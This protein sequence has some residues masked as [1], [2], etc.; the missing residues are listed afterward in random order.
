MANITCTVNI[1]TEG[2]GY[3]VIHGGAVSTV[4]ATIR[5][6]TFV[7]IVNPWDPIGAMHPWNYIET[8]QPD[9]STGELDLMRAISQGA[10]APFAETHSTYGPTTLG[11][12]GLD[13]S[14]IWTIYTDEQQRIM[15]TQYDINTQTWQPP[16]QIV[17]APSGSMNPTIGFN[18]NG[19]YVTSVELVPA[20]TDQH[21]IWI[22]EPPYEGA[23]IRNV[24]SGKFPALVLDADPEN[25]RYEQFEERS[26]WMVSETFHKNT[27]LV[28][29]YQS[30]DGM[31]LYYRRADEGYDV[32]HEVGMTEPGEKRMLAAYQALIPIGPSTYTYRDTGFHLMVAYRDSNNELRYVISSRLVWLGRNISGVEEISLVDLELSDIMLED[33]RYDILITV[34]DDQGDPVPETL[35][36]VVEQQDQEELAGITDSNGQIPFLIRPYSTEYQ[37][38][39]SHAEH[40]EADFNTILVYGADETRYKEFDIAWPQNLLFED[41]TA[42]N[43]LIL[44]D[45]YLEMYTMDIEITVYDDLGAVVPDTTVTVLAQR[46]QEEVTGFTDANGQVI[47][48]LLPYDTAYDVILSHETHGEADHSSILISHGEETYQTEFD[49]AF[50]QTMLPAETT[51][52]SLFEIE[53]I[54]W[55]DA[56]YTV[57]ITVYNPEGQTVTDAN[58]TVIG[59]QFQETVE[60]TTDANGEVQFDLLPFT[61]P[62]QVAVNHQDYEETDHNEITVYGEDETQ[63]MAFDVAF[64]QQLA[65][66]EHTEVGEFRLE[67]ILYVEI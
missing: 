59:Q 42:L 36:T 66:T 15:L 64:K 57:T 4:S 8:T 61:A 56:H 1:A 6:E 9:F 10:L 3:K 30:Q 29:F 5:G 43:Q 51:L 18:S 67:A 49:L 53:D 48:P 54:A 63:T 26:G 52:I 55:W 25:Y 7:C 13:Y 31:T 62:Y 46:D 58:V 20:G 23:A 17:Y 16:V 37:V 60:G 44:E 34:Y 40:G 50:V 65:A 45:I 2:A 24:A 28:L 33:M 38:L 22:I 12:P 21:E 32:E 39:I 19:D 27:D 14:R 41:T 11:E 47:L 35:V